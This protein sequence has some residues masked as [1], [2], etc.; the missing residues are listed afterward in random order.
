MII[1]PVDDPELM[2]ILRKM[3][4]DSE[5]LRRAPRWIRWLLGLWIGYWPPLLPLP[6]L[7]PLRPFD[8]F[9]PFEPGET[10]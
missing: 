9:Q 6:K 5:R 2:K 7:P 10:P 3:D 8:P 4:R 1:E